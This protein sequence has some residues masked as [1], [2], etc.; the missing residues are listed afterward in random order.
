MCFSFVDVFAY[1]IF[2]SSWGDNIA[3]RKHFS[4]IDDE[5][6]IINNSSTKTSIHPSRV[7]E[8]HVC[9]SKKLPRE[10][11]NCEILL[12]QVNI[13]C[14]MWFLEFASLFPVMLTNS[15][16]LLHI[17]PRGKWYELSLFSLSA[18]NLIKKRITPRSPTGGPPSTSRAASLTDSVHVNILGSCYTYSLPHP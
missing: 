4:I 5:N 12:V 18:K 15:D 13:L 10:C 17:S 14:R 16:T 8:C 1:R 6:W 7:N 11:I 2:G 9:R 3:K